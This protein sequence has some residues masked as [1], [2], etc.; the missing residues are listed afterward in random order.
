[1]LGPWRGVRPPERRPRRPFTPVLYGE[2][3]AHGHAEL[4]LLL[5]GRCRFSFDHRGSVL[6]TGDLVICPPQ[7]PHAEAYRRPGEGYRLAW[8]SLSEAEPRL[9]VTRYAR[10]GGFTMEHGM[11][12]ALLPG[13]ARERLAALRRLAASP[14][15]PSAEA[16]REALLTLTL[17]LYRRVLDGGAAQLD[18]RAELVRRAAAQVRAQAGRA[19]T[20]AE[21]ARE[22]QVSPNYLTALFRAETGTPLGR[23]I[24]EERIV[25]AQRRLREPGATVKAVALDLAFADPFTFSRAFKRVTGRSPQ[26]WARLAR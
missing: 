7:C 6:E 13:E 11:N 17:A 15:R 14:R 2:E 20:L 24:L 4:C 8:W 9:H 18:T 12:L 19:L 21:V 10:R 3:H 1:M 22:A 5:A 16:L 26:A 25:L 23:F